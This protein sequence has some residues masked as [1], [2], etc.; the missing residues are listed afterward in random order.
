MWIPVLLLIVGLGFVLAEVLFPSFG[1]LSIL[2]GLCILGA[3]AAAFAH[4]SSSGVGFSVATAVLLPTVIVVGLKLFPRTPMGRRMVAGGLSFESETA[5]D[6]R[7]RSLVGKRGVVEAD[8]R[9]AGYA[10]IDGRRVDVVSRGESIPAGTS[11]RVSE[12]RG[13]RVVVVRDEE[14]ES[15]QEELTKEEAS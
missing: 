7:D 11:V 13:N 3:I 6:A 12:V 14:N 2:A 15:K 1:V 5:T 4:G 10:R 8:C 9:P